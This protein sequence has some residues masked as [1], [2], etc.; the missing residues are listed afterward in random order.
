MTG[1]SVNEQI[2]PMCSFVLRRMR[3]EGRAARLEPSSPLSALVL[4]DIEDRRA[5][6]AWVMSW[7][8]KRAE[9]TWEE[10]GGDD[11][12]ARVRASME[13]QHEMQGHALRYLV[14]RYRSHPRFRQEWLV[15]R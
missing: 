3:E 13:R 10:H 7:A 14:A 2:R 12:G 8:L 15:P 9:G 11:D 6:I 5:L 1:V 4:A